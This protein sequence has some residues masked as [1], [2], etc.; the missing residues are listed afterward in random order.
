MQSTRVK[1]IVGVL[2]AQQLCMARAAHSIEMVL[3]IIS[4]LVSK[5]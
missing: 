3:L 2:N 4:Y 1:D 5:P